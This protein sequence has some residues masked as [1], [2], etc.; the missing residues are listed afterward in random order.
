VQ[1]I[2]AADMTDRTVMLHVCA[3]SSDMRIAYA[4]GEIIVE[5]IDGKVIIDGE[6]H[7]AIL[8]RWLRINLTC[9]L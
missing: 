6:R 5:R 1:E 2:G 3:V 7:R 9:S 8:A 4:S